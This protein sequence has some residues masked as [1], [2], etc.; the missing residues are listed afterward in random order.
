MIIRLTSLLKQRTIQSLLAISIYLIIAPYS[1]LTLHKLLYTISLF[2][3]DLLVL[4]MPLTVCIFISYTVQSFKS[5]A[6]L[7][8]FILVLFEA[9][10]NWSCVWYAFGTAH[11][12]V[13]KCLTFNNVQESNLFLPLWRLGLQVPQWWSP[14]KGTLIGIILGVFVALKQDLSLRNTLK[15]SKTILDTVLTKFFARLIPLFILGFTAKIYQTS[16]IDFTQ[17]AHSICWLIMFLGA[18]IIFLFTLGAGLSIARVM[19]H[20][21]NILPAGILA[22]TSGCSLSTMPFTI[23]GTSKNLKNPN[24]ARA[25]IPATTNIQQIGDVIANTFLCFLIYTHFFGHTPSLS[26]WIPFSIFFVLARFATAAVIGGAI[27]LMLP[28]Y[29]KYLSFNNEMITIIL[30]LNVILDPIITSSNVI[31]NC[32]LA[33][34]FEKV[35]QYLT[36][37]NYSETKTEDNKKAA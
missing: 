16:L 4:M 21:K 23:E 30:G 32:A 25:I 8:I 27:F 19:L 36:K 14:D 24:L 33:R 13:G 9:M 22:L 35:W 10:S 6:P 20:I 3:K 12:I 26:V 11:T 15:K 18:Y 31:A 29:E 5:K 37:E 1:P 17:Y 34:V 2:I 28:I 7:F